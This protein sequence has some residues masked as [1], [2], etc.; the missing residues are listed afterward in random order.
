[1]FRKKLF[2]INIKIFTDGEIK[3]FFRTNTLYRFGR[4]KLCSYIANYTIFTLNEIKLKYITKKFNDY[5]T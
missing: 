5:Y 1:M 3:I 4:N 2:N